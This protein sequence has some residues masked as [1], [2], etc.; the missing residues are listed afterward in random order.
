VAVDVSGRGVLR[1]PRGIQVC[2]AA[3]VIELP[4]KQNT[5]V[6]SDRVSWSVAGNEHVGK[7]KI[8]L[9]VSPQEAP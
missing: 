6:R 4:E 8:S 9:Y 2:S 1:A 7:F 3:V 5:G